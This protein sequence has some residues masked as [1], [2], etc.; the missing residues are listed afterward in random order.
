M[1]F[2]ILTRPPQLFF[3]IKN[4]ILNFIRNLFFKRP[5]SFGPQEVLRSLLDGLKEINFDY[6][7]NSS[8]KNVLLSDI[9]YVPN[10]VAALRWAISM[11]KRGK[12]KKIVAG[13][14]LVI[15][16][17]EKRGILLKK[18]IDLII[19]PSKWVAD[20]YVSLAP[21]IKTK[22][23]IWPA[24]TKI[25]PEQNGDKKFCLV[26]KKSCSEEL[27][28]SITETLQVNAI[29]FKILH[30]GHYLKEDYFNLLR[31]ARFMIYLSES[32][33]QGLALQ[34]A[35]MHNVPTLVWNREYM[36][37]GK[38]EWRG[39]TSAPYLSEHSGLSFDNKSNFK[40]SFEKFL[41]NISNFHPRQYVL[42]HLT[43]RK[44]AEKFIKIIFN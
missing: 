21:E 18:E 23:K 41:S 4:K 31:N 43:D 15:S 10:S 22:I 19:V 13:P 39:K 28:K 3:L 16:P 42:N 9:I 20:F 30:Y 8:K 32:E 12:I 7:L 14:N 33:S 40:F 1:K 35:W 27:F 17:I 29:A 34:E 25:I 38:Y 37:S 11:K 6:S 2:V 26:Y 36:R 44:S 5:V 24:G